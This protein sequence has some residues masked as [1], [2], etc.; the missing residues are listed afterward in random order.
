MVT[1]LLSIRDRATLA[2]WLSANM[3][4]SDVEN[5]SIVGAVEN[6]R[7]N[8]SIVKLYEMLWTWSAHR[9]HGDAGQLQDAYEARFGSQRLQKR[10]DRCNKLIKRIK[11]SC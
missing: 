8:E 9:F 5:L 11:G 10:I 3:A 1:K 4:M 7:F 2:S 6:K